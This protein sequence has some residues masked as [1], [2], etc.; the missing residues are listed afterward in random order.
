VGAAAAVAVNEA[1]KAKVANP[2]S[3]NAGSYDHDLVFAYFAPA[4]TIADL[5][6]G[7]T[8]EFTIEQ[9]T[10]PYNTKT[11]PGFEI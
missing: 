2:S 9:V 3:A 8:V 4:S 1:S 6:P 10:N 11:V 7:D 5:V